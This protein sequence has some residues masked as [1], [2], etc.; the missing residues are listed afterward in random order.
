[1]ELF[2][3]EWI[4]SERISGFFCVLALCEMCDVVSFEDFERW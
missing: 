4:Q 1:M 3:F 2:I